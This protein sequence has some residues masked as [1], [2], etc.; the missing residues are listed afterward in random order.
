VFFQFEK[1]RKDVTNKTNI[2]LE[3]TRQVSSCFDNS[4]IENVLF[5]SKKN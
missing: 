1:K 4:N 5:R 3:N 2:V